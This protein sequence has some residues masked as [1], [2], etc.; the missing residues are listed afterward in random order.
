MGMSAEKWI[1]TE[2]PLLYQYLAAN[3]ETFAYR[4][5]GVSAQGGDLNDDIDSLTNYARQTERIAVV[6]PEVGAHDLTG[7]VKWVM[8]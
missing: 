5:Y 2:V 1:K 8:S 6:G 7:I 4:V 3:V